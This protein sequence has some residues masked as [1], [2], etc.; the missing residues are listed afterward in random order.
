MSKITMSFIV[1]AWC[2]KKIT[3][4]HQQKDKWTV[5]LTLFFWMTRYT[6]FFLNANGHTEPRTDTASYRD[7]TAH[8]KTHPDYCSNFSIPSTS[9][10]PSVDENSR[11]VIFEKLSTT[12]TCLHLAQCS[13]VFWCTRYSYCIHSLCK[14]VFFNFECYVSNLMFS[15][16]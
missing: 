13:S 8:L 12:M 3:N 9:S 6:V 11:W 5:Q 4:K 2:L 14:I 16:L 10:K 1:Y 7:T 15:V